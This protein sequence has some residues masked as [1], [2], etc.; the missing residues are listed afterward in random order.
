M[1]LCLKAARILLSFQ[2][3]CLVDIELQ[4]LLFLVV[5]YGDGVYPYPFLHFLSFYEVNQRSSNE[6]CYYDAFDLRT[7]KN[8]TNY[9]AYGDYCK[10]K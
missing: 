10:I 4:Y 9:D 3:F 5:L 2:D 6:F 7:L 1:L 8:E